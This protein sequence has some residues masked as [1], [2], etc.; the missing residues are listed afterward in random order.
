MSA[1]KPEPVID[2]R[3]KDEVAFYWRRYRDPTRFAGWDEE[4][5]RRL[6]PAFQLAFSQYVAFEILADLAA[7]AGK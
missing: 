7:E 2:S 5:C 4:R 6:M 3:F 1:P